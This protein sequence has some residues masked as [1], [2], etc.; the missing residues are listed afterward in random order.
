MHILYIGLLANVTNLSVHS[1]TTS[2]TLTWIPPFSLDITG[3]EPDFTHTVEVYNITSGDRQE[4]GVYEN[5]TDSTFIFTLSDDESQS[6]GSGMSSTDVIS[7]VNPDPSDL[8]EFIV[9][10][11]NAVERGE[12]SGLVQGRFKEGM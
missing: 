10:A 11:V 8:F 3:V 2:I 1:T 6:I 12:P 9:T 5:I 7:L 4:V